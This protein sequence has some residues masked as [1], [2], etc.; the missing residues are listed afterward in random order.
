MAAIGFATLSAGAFSA[1]AHGLALVAAAIASAS[2]G[3]LFHNRPPARVFLGDSGSIPLGFLAATLGI[4]GVDAGAWPLAFPILAFSPFIVDATVTILRRLARGER[5]W[6]AHR[7]HYDPRLVLSGW[8]RAR[9]A[10]AAAGVMV[11]AGAS[12]LVLRTEGVMV[13]CGI[14]SGWLVA[15][16]AALIAI[17]RKTRRMSDS[18]Q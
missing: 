7:S 3:F 17:D 14:I 1:G 16:A 2:V 18:A 6:K 5:I 8:S 4:H 15:Y 10:A 11:L 9:L 13:Q 12:A